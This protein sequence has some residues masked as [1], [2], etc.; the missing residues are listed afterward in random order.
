MDW[1]FL[2]GQDAAV[3][4]L[5]RDLSSDRV[6]NAYIFHG[7]EG[8]GKSTAATLFAKALQCGGE[9]PPCGE[10]TACLKI[11]RGVHP[12]VIQ[13]RPPEGKKSIGVEH[14][15]ETMIGRAV[16]R[17][18]EGNRQIF[19]IGEAHLVT[20]GA[21]NALLKTLEE[22]SY[23]TVIIL[24]TQNLHALPPTVVSRCRRLI[25][26]SL[27]REEQRAVLAANI[28]GTEEDLDRL[29]SLSLGRLGEALRIDPEV[30]AERREAALGFLE[31]LAAPAGKADLIDLLMVASAQ[32]SKGDSVRAEA[33]SFLEMLL[34]LLRDILILEVAPGGIEPWNAD[35]DEALRAF[36]RRW[37]TPGLIQAMDRVETAVRD[38]GEINTNP[39]L[40]LES[41]VIGLRGTVGAGS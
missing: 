3:A 28:E 32:G 21:F 24:V 25:F 37:G 29:I 26:R 30:L 5:R 35:L 19:I 6:A 34:G 27:N 17:P 40:T 12:D 4:S 11:D 10:C 23:D 20:L 2:K 7:P 15:R 9:T 8:V 1:E 16:Q 33:L 31:E 36:G 14:I 39:S 18:Q 41:L 13:V 38:V 22:P